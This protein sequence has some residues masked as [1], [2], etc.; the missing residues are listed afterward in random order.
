M[1]TTN[2]LLTCVVCCE[3]S[4]FFSKTSCNHISTCLKCTLRLRTYY[5]DT[6]CPLCNLPSPYA[7]IIT[8]NDESTTSTYES[9]LKESQIYYK[10]DNFSVNTIYYTDVLSQEE[11]ISLQMYK[12]PEPQCVADSFDTYNELKSHMKESHNKFYC[13]ICVKYNKKFIH[14]QKVYQ[15]NRELENHFNYGEVINK[16]INNKNEI[17]LNIH[18]HPLCKF[19]GEYFYDKESFYTH[20][21]EKHFQCEICKKIDKKILF[22]SRFEILLQHNKFFHY[23][24][25]FKECTDILLVAFAYSDD[26]RKHIIEKHNIDPNINSKKLNKLLSENKPLHISYPD[27]YESNFIDEE[28]NFNEYTEALESEA[29]RHYKIIN[30]LKQNDYEYNNNNNNNYYHNNRKHNKKG[31]IQQPQQYD[32][33]FKFNHFVKLTKDY[34]LNQKIKCDKVVES[35]FIIPKETQYQMIIIID[36]IESDHKCMELPSIQNFGLSL[37]NISLITKCLTQGDKVDKEYYY[38]ILDNLNIKT[39]LIVYKYFGICYKKVNKDFFKLELEQ[40]NENLYSEFVKS[41]KSNNIYDKGNL[42]KDMFMNSEFEQGGKKKKG[43]KKK[44]NWDQRKVVGLTEDFHK[45]KGKVISS[46]NNNIV[47]NKLKFHEQEDIKEKEDNTYNQKQQ[48]QNNN[49]NNNASQKKSKLAMLLA[50]EQPKNTHKTNKKGIFDT[51][52]DEEFPALK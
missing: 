14:E 25:P 36:K 28:L 44:F 39:V 52:D 8:Y 46:S 29:L 20:M 18:T 19:C 35:D 5:N 17:I 7:F 42:A 47:N 23:R 3:Q 49:N 16:E 37:D 34:I 40:L 41:K 21:T 50:F 22:Y 4:S 48:Q 12:C 51:R 9:Y 45:P 30:K 13:D 38:S 26:L 31:N 43:K 11:G 24:C 33:A 1:E 6:K 2:D 32:Y 27:H 10:D 15:S